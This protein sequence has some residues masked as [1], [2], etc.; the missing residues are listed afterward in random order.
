[1][2][3]I[4]SHLHLNW[5]MQAP[6]PGLAHLF[7]WLWRVEVDLSCCNHNFCLV[8]IGCF[9]SS[10]VLPHQGRM[11]DQGFITQ[12]CSKHRE[13]VFKC[14]IS[15][16]HA[17]SLHTS[18]L[19]KWQVSIS[20]G[21]TRLALTAPIT[22]AI[23][24]PNSENLQISLQKANSSNSWWAVH[25]HAGSRRDSSSLQFSWFLQQYS[26]VDFPTKTPTIHWITCIYTAQSTKFSISSFNLHYCR[27]VRTK[28]H[29][30]Q[31]LK[32]CRALLWWF[33]LY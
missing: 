6:V 1:M 2:L 19:W 17:I 5:L 30:S 7:S 11:F 18:A 10:C 26:S 21:R 25:R 4:I 12:P 16:L 33:L 32:A 8:C 24:S 20:Q 31:N 22:R 14:C 13:Q 29:C 28:N 3:C 15:S 9:S 27:R 23:P